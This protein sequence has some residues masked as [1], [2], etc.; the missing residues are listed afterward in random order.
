MRT[1]I[2]ILFFLS[3][4]IVLA[5]DK[6]NESGALIND[7]NDKW[8]TKIASNSEMRSRILDMMI[9]ETQGNEEET[10]KLVNLM[11]N[12]QEINSMMLS[13]Q[14]EKND[15]ENLSIQPRGI[16]PDSVKSGKTYKL[17]PMHKK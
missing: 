5:Q 6:V 2:I 11:I 7:Q 14:S 3:T 4:F 10:M 16:M 13:L 12:N 8:M 1:L 9:K 15:Y 17:L